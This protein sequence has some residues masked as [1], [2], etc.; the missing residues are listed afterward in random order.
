MKRLA[1]L[2][3]LLIPVGAAAQRLDDS[4]S[5]QQQVDVNLQWQYPDH[6]EQLDD[7]QFNA[8]VAHIDRYEL[9]LNTAAQKGTTARI[10]LGLPVVIR[11]LDDPGAVRLSWTGHGTFA[12]GTVTPG[13]RSLLYEGPITSDVMIDMLDF[14]IAIDGRS[15]RQPITIEPEYEIETVTP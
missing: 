13:M 2:L 9:R 1:C 14:T 3:G 10:Y 12:D 8:T 5:P 6:V 11:G 15:F 4:Q 7:G